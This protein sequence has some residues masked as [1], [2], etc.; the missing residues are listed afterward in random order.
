V[1]AVVGADAAIPLLDH[2][3]QRVVGIGDRGV[4]VTL[5]P[6][7]R[8]GDGTDVLAS[9]ARGGEDEQEGD[10]CHALLHCGWRAIR[11]AA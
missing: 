10:S 5:R 6:L 8:A 11:C 4:V 3:E 1:P 2:P 7:V 9:A